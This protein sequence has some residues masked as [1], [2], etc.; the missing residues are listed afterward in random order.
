MSAAAGAPQDPEPEAEE[1]APAWMATFGD[2]MSLLLTFFVLLL[3]FANTDVVKFREMMGS[4][5]DAFGVQHEHPGEFEGRTTSLVQIWDE[6]AEPN[7]FEGLPG[8]GK[9]S[10]LDQE[11]ARAIEAA[12]A[13]NDL[14]GLVE[15][16]QSERGVV[17]RIA[18]QLLFESASAELRP[19]SF[20][21][22]DR[23]AELA[24]SFPHNLTIEGHTDD[25][26]VRSPEF[27]TNWHLSSGRSIAAL[28]YLV[29]EGEVD[30][31]KLSCTGFADMRPL[32]PNDS[33]QRRARNRRIEFLFTAPTQSGPFG[34]QQTD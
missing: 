11:M 31:K 6:E 12:V 13:D 4:I 24:R 27:P 2:M 5:Q 33:P 26:P 25:L 32:V 7:P 20:A 10:E 1:G 19:Q 28:R 16:E 21:L 23:I 14:G 30:P 8:A 15:I 9:D 17:M 3:S 18:G 29:E 22:L 34:A